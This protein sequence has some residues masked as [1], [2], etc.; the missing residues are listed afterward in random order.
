MKW[1]ENK[2]VNESDDPAR[3]HGT[4]E[5]EAPDS[6]GLRACATPAEDCGQPGRA[7]T[8][9]SWAQ[10]HTPPR[11]P[12]QRQERQLHGPPERLLQGAA[13]TPA[14]RGWQVP[15]WRRCPG[16]GADTVGAPS[17]CKSKM[18]RGVLMQ[19]MKGPGWHFPSVLTKRH[20][21]PIKT[22]M[23]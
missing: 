9:G 5:K 22:E 17:T 6:A 23:S 13:T 8:R 2:N 15:R 14:L 16:R 10:D 1:G 18:C 3:T 20:T 11:P 19:P 12:H 21:K 7:L 4:K